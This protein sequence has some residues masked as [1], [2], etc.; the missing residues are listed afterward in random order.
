MVSIR[1][2]RKTLYGRRLRQALDDSIGHHG[3]PHRVVV[4]IAENEVAQIP[5]AGPG[6]R[7]MVSQREKGGEQ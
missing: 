4:Y 6:L 7:T 1:Q 2:G 3:I 5:A